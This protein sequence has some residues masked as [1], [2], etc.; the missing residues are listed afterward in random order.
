MLLHTPFYLIFLAFSVSFYWLLPNINCRKWFLLIASYVF[1]SLF[2]WRFA[3]LLLFLTWVTFLIGLAI[4]R[5]SHARFFAWL[6][7]L[8]NF[9]ILGVFKY[10]NFFL[11][12]VESLWAAYDVNLLSVGLRLILPIGISFYSFQAIS[13]TTEI[14][15]KK[16]EPVTK[17]MDFAIYLSFFP[18]LIAGPLVQPKRF[19]EQLESPERKFNKDTFKAALLLLLLGLVKK[20]IIADSLASRGDV[21]FRAASLALID[22]QFPSP[23]YIQGF[24][25][26]AYQIYAD[27]SGYTDIALASAAMLGFK[28]PQNFRQPYLSSTIIE[29]WNR[30]HMSLTRWFREYLFFPLS[31]RLLIVSRRKHTKVVQ[32]SVNL[33]TMTL[34]G[35][36][37]GAAWTFVIWGL[38]HGVLLSIQHL[39]NVKPRSKTSKFLTGLLTFHLVGFGWIIFASV[40]IISAKSFFQGLFAFHGMRW[41]PLFIPSIL[42]TS[43]LV[44]GIDLVQGGYLPIPTTVKKYGQPVLIIAG[45]GVLV[46]L[47]ILRFASG[48]D[49]RPFIYGQF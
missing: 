41:L 46:S 34:I 38:Y 3:A 12:S 8:I 44:F 36:W 15:R 31:R 42:V 17:W 43:V 4:K 24:Y 18:K 2:D 13:Y 22:G 16:I 40:S 45:I 9:G 49:V 29:F 10:M 47:Y 35:L 14:Y 48:S 25:L 32:T 11:N 21:A 39:L 30:W 1:Y 28:L 23:V 26:Y 5:S 27:F 19:L 33:V 20:V 7:V 6:S 37:H